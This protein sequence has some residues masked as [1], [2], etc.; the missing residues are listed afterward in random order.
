[1]AGDHTEP[2]T[3]S[4]RIQVCIEA[5]GLV[6][7][8]WCLQ[9]Q[10]KANSVFIALS[11]SQSL[12]FLRKTELASRFLNWCLI[13]DIL[14]K[15]LVKYCSFPQSFYWQAFYWY[16]SWSLSVAWKA[17]SG[18]TLCFSS[19][20]AILVNFWWKLESLMGNSKALGGLLS[21]ILLDKQVNCISVLR[22]V[23]HSVCLYAG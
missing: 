12:T 4:E 8:S 13:T 7:L 2:E 17:T 20:I 22:K 9:T 1:M 10:S 23:F 16:C 11:E 21:H 14:Q 5:I 18:T 19:Y 6:P 15:V 3:L